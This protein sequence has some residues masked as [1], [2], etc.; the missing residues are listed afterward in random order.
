[1]NDSPDTDQDAIL[2]F[3]GDPESHGGAPVDRID[4]HISHV[5][6][7]GDKAYKLKKA[8]KLDFLDF[9][10]VELRQ[11][12][13]E[14]ELELNRRL[15]PDLYLG[16]EPITREDD[17]F[18]IS[19]S[20]TPADWLVVMKR[21]GQE[22]LFDHLVREGELT[23]DL[24]NRLADRVVDLHETIEKRPDLGGPDSM[25]STIRNA[26]EA[27]EKASGAGLSLDA[28]E[29][30]CTRLLAEVRKYSALLEERRLG[31]KVRYCHGDMHLAN[32]CLHN[33]EPTLFDAIEFDDAIACIDVLYDI[34]FPI[35][36]LVNFKRPDLASL[37]MNRYLESSADY[38]GACLMPLFLSAR[39]A[40]RAMALG[41]TAESPEFGQG[42][43]GQTV[44]HARPILPGLVA[45]PAHCC[46]RDVG[47]GQ[48]GAGARSRPHDRRTA[49]RDHAAFRRHPKKAVRQTP[50][51]A[52]AAGSLHIRGFGACLRHVA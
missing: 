6:L 3:L 29:D 49:G 38:S 42:Q 46:R 40:I 43:T 36:D 9:S 17:G 52:P 45:A 14:R 22:D 26:F 23:P 2:A 27:L 19:G 12:A 28:E 20:G 44:L 34:A 4:T 47:N 33:G 50:G 30:L 1:M 21:F 8:V 41:L 37:L 31:G 15:S 32:I 16:V 39:A 48:I 7:T 24:I 11:K 25:K 35:M 5:F 10:T 18:R 13:C 51:R